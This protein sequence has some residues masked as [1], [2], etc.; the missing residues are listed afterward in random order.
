MLQV[1]IPCQYAGAFINKRQRAAVCKPFQFAPGII[2]RLCFMN[3]QVGTFL[4]FFGFNHT[5]RITIHK[6]NIIDRP[7]IGGIF[8]NRQ[9]Q[10][11]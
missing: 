1:G 6:Q 10:T 8:P 7:R 4:F 5:H 9:P 3:A 2:F 11:T